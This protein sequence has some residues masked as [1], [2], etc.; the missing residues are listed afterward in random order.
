MTRPCLPTPAMRRSSV[1]AFTLALTTG[2]AA[3]S[4][5]LGRMPSGG[6]ASKRHTH[7][8]LITLLE[9]VAGDT[10]GI[11]TDPAVLNARWTEHTRAAYESTHDRHFLVR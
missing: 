5:Q 4:M 10:F 7:D 1:A 3:R 11:A 6:V 9:R 2:F 8:A